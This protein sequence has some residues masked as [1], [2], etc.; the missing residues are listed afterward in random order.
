MNALRAYWRGLA[1]RERRVLAGGAAAALAVLGYA[2]L[3]A[4]WQEELARLRTR[5]PALE[6]DLAWMTR[7]AARLQRLEGT[8]RGGLPPLS[9]LE[10]SARAR[11]LA[12]AIR[13]MRPAEDR[14]HIALQ[15]AP[16]DAWLRWL[17]DLRRQGVAVVAA[18]VERSAA[19][20][21]VQVRMTLARRGGGTG[22]GIAP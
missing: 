10:R 17:E 21:R 3:W 4:P 14:V 16:F 7:A 2:L 12:D 15:D 8:A 19:P 18:R 9:V 20:G 6:Q 11:G 22:S 13:Q 1:P 5:V